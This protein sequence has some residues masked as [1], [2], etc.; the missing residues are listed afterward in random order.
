MSKQQLFTDYQNQIRN[1][2]LS[3]A[4]GFDYA[5]NQFDV[6]MQFDSRCLPF[7]KSI[8]LEKTTMRKIERTYFTFAQGD[9]DFM[10]RTYV[11]YSLRI[12]WFRFS[13]C[14]TAQRPISYSV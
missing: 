7:C 12:F 4:H 6:Q 8:R 9:S 3:Q 14:P 1:P 2:L 10:L 13:F 5:A 11:W